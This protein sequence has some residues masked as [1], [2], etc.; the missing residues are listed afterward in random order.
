MPNITV[1]LLEGRTL[2]QKRAMARE[3]TKV[4]CDIC[5][6]PASAVTVRFE[7]MAKTDYAK[8]GILVSDS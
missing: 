7:D 2:E 1:A 6:V 3:I 5:N 8:A 4:V